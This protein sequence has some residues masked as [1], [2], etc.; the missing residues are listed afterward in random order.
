V[1]ALSVR[2]SRLTDWVMATPGGS[3]TQNQTINVPIF[4]GSS[5]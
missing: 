1:D 5:N 4:Y 2:D 3:W